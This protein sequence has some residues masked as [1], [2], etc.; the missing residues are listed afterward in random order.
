MAAEH[1]LTF[2]WD[3]FR[4]EMEQHGENRAPAQ[5]IELF[6]TGPLDA[7][8]K[9]MHGTEFLGYETTGAPRRR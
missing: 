1:N 3:G 7:L 9:A 2:D 6:Q 5:K 8:K 4:E